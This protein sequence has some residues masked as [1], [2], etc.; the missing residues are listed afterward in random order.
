MEVKIVQVN[1]LCESMVSAGLAM[2][3]N[4]DA[5]TY[6]EEVNK[7]KT[8]IASNINDNAHIERAIKLASIKSP[9][10]NNFLK[11][12]N[13]LLNVTA[14][15]A[16]YIQAERYIF[17]IPVSCMSKMHRLIKMNLDTI[18]HP[19]VDKDM[20]TIFKHKVDVFNKKD[21]KTPEDF[22]SLV[23][24]CPLGLELTGTFTTNYMCLKNIY[25]QRKN[26]KLKEW[27]IFCETL[28]ELPLF[29]ELIAN[30]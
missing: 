21:N 29:K 23:Y 1:N 17:F 3:E 25:I 12:V 19:L 30:D 24:S 18:F 10:H 6:F 5:N 11:G 9:G 26:H 22:E 27:H 15:N 14:T 16:W 28:K 13:V 2:Q 4:Y 20:I 7:L 8:C